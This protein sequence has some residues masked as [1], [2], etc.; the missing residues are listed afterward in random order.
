VGALAQAHPGL[1]AAIAELTRRIQQDP[2]NAELFLGRA[3]AHRQHRDWPAAEADYREARRLDP[4]LQVVDL[5][6]GKM[7]LDSG[8]AAEAKARLDTFLERQPSH[9]EALGTRARALVQLGKPLA[10][11]AD[12]SRA[13]ASAPP[14]HHARVDFYLERARALESAGA[15][16]RAEALEGLEQGIRELNAPITLQLRAIELAIEMKRYDAALARIEEAASRA[17]RKELWLLRQG[18][19]LELAGRPDQARQSFAAVLQAVDSLPATR[20]TNRAMQEL[21]AQ[22]QAALARLGSSH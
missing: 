1:D 13:L 5:A 18:E 14:G 9:P 10:A 7:M 15:S 16:H 11:A 2:Q 20:R 22:A 12:F 19:V 8:R 17:A 21:Q 6:L 4:Q 3:E